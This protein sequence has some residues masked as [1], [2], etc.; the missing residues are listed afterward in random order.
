[1]KEDEVGLYGFYI[2]DSEWSQRKRLGGFIRFGIYEANCN[3]CSSLYNSS[4]KLPDLLLTIESLDLKDVYVRVWRYRVDNACSLN[5]LI[6][7]V[8]CT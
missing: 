3:W 1:M 6:Y 4:Y 2:V 5:Y 7:A 8:T